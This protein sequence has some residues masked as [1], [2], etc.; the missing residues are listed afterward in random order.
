LR[1]KAT[2]ASSG[3]LETCY[4]HIDSLE[5]VE[6]RLPSPPFFRIHRFTIVSLDRVLKIRL[7]GERAC[8]V[9]LDLPANRLM[10]ASRDRFPALA[11]LLGI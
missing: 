11:E 3:E 5:E 8:E 2:T 7:R 1:Q 9:K 10:P 6:Q 4:K